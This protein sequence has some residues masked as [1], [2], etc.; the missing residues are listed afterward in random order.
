MLKISIT[1][2]ISSGKT[3]V[4]EYL[5]RNKSVFIFNA[6]KESKRHLK[7]SISIQKKL[8]HIF[9]DKIIKNKKIDFNLLAKEAFSNSTNHKILNGILWPEVYILIN[10]AFEYAKKNNYKLFIVDAALIFEANFSSFFDKNILIITKKDK[11]IKRAIK[12][13]NISLESIQNRM[14]LQMSDNK[15]KKLSDITIHNND[16]I[17]SLYKKIDNLYEKLILL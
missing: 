6:D 15:K 4:T 11:R 10:N 7:S 8:T 3:T 9:S 5:N 13:S 16:D 17:K 1:G 14:R 12:R 2:G